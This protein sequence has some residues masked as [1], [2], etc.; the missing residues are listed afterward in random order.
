MKKHIYIILPAFFP[1]PA[2]KGGA[3][4]TLV[5]MFIEQ[6]EVEKKYKITV[7]SPYNELSQKY[8]EKY[9]LTDFIY[10]K[11]TYYNN[12]WS[13]LKYKVSIIFHKL[14]H[15]R[16]YF[17]DDYHR[18]V[19]NYI[20]KHE[21]PEIC[22]VEG[23]S[24]TVEFKKISQIIGMDKMV[25]HVH[26]CKEKCKYEENIFSN[27]IFVSKFAKDTWDKQNNKGLYVLKNGIDIQKFAKNYTDEEIQKEREKLG[28]KENDFVV[29]F[30]GRLVEVKGI[31]ELIQAILEIR[32]PNMKLLVVGSVSFGNAKV[33]EYQKEIE[34]LASGSQKIKF[35][36]FIHN[37]KIP[38]LYHLA[39]V[40]V[41]P[42]IYEEAAGL[43]VM[44]AMASGKPMV[45]TRSGGMPEFVVN[46]GCIMVNKDKDTLVEELK[47]ALEKLY[48][49]NELCIKMGKINYEASKQFDEKNY[50]NNFSKIIDE[51]T[52]KSIK[53]IK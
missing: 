40:A 52:E 44:E 26:Y 3:V 16:P 11:H 15:I 35:T 17:L 33:T 47:I 14:I 7:F 29:I 36:G 28:F 46:D 1:V 30:C 2:V 42:S 49:D 43:V 21:L 8:S 45:I 41:V 24:A 4:E 22:I 10:I 38:I 20:K 19:Y 39:Q 53:D 23:G 50:Y 31:K 37:D 32:Y 27:I 51:I 13:K 48:L 34:E 18:E 9:E 6:N 12:K 25:L 5:E